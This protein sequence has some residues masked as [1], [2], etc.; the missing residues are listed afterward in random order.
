M[1][2]LLKKILFLQETNK[3]LSSH[4][5]LKSL[6]EA[7]GGAVYAVAKCD[8]FYIFLVDPDT[9]D[10]NVLFSSTPFSADTFRRLDEI[11]GREVWQEQNALIEPFEALR[12]KF[13]EFARAVSSHG[14]APILHF[15][16]PLTTAHGR[17]GLL[18]GFSSEET[19]E[20]DFGDPQEIQFLRLFADLVAIAVENVMSF[21]GL[22]STKAQLREERDHLKRLVEVSS[23][24]ASKLD[25]AEIVR[26]I[27][28]K[29]RTV[30]GSDYVGLLTL[31]NGTRALYRKVMLFPGGS[32]F[33]EGSV[34]RQ[35]T[36]PAYHA[37]TSK[38]TR[39]YNRYDLEKMSDK[40]E[41]AAAMLA[42]HLYALCSV[43][44]I[45]RGEVMGVL[46]VGNVDSEV[47]PEDAAKLLTEL[48][49]QVAVSVA[50][51]MAYENMSGLNVKLVEEK[52]YLEEELQTLG[53]F[54]EIIGQSDA[55]KAV[56]KRIRMVADSDSNVLVIGETG[57]GKELVARAI[58]NWSRRHDQTMVKLSCAAIPS[59]LLESELFGHERG[60]F[61]GAIRQRIGRL[62]LANKGTLFLD[63]VGDI[64]LELQPKLLRALQEREFERLGGSRI[65][66]TDARIIAATNRDLAQMIREGQFRSD[67]Y[68]RLN[69][70]PIV[71]PPLRERKS[72]IPL[73]V[74]HFVQKYGKRMGRN[75]EIIP[76]EL[77]DA[78]TE[79]PWHGNVRELE[80]VME[81]AVILSRSNVLTLPFSELRAGE[82]PSTTTVAAKEEKT[83]VEASDFYVRPDEKELITRILRETNGVLAGPR[84]AS[85]RLRI[86]RTTLLAKIKR[87]GIPR[88]PSLVS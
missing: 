71:V 47:F 74:R 85:A 84:G 57:T 5:D 39:T 9:E 56:L 37:I 67:L 78:L 76:A 21:E 3:A 50:N 64:P 15:I 65:I 52:L 54:T 12:S 33:D 40:C 59:G 51:A 48:A 44:L 35:R 23:V 63:E 80:N 16:M 61:T 19:S 69:V 43:P 26:A 20:E 41:I 4:R 49:P 14:H 2:P 34:V 11:P 29:V 75:I 24:V 28:E 25:V 58:H 68:Y 73:L 7:V 17:L 81:R 45:L 46:E 10:V 88:Y 72:D 6:S 30:L 70:F 55:L 18:S 36:C 38:R 31:E 8:H 79:L 42:A 83:I 66:H 32:L 27:A 77:I 22:C 60:A 53:D 87:L 62:E 1:D 82:T 86:K 13:P